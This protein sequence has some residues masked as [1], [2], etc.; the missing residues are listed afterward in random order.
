[1]QL[2]TSFIDQELTY[3]KG[4]GPSRSEL[5]KNELSIVSIRDILVDYPTRYEDRTQFQLIKDIRTGNDVVQIRGVITSL[6]TVGTGRK[7]RLVGHFKDKSGSVEL[8]W[9]RSIRWLQ[10]NL[11]THKPYIVFGRV[12]KF[13]RR[14]SIAHPELELVTQQKL[15]STATFVP[16]Y[17]STE[18]L[19][20]SG[21]DSKGRRKI[22]RTILAQLKDEDLPEHM[23]EYLVKKLHFPSYKDALHY[24][25]FPPDNEA[26]RKAEQRLK[27]EE[28]FLI[29][30]TIVKQY[31]TRRKLLK[32]HLFPEIGDYFNDFY[33]NHLPFS[34]TG[35]QKRVLKEIRRDFKSGQQMN[36]LL[37]GDVGSGKTIVALMS[38][39]MA[40]DNG[41]QACLMAPTEILAQQ[42][43]AGICELLA[44]TKIR[45][46]ILTG[47]IKGKTRQE[48]LKLLRLGEIHFLVG[49]HALIEE[50]VQFKHLG[51][52]IID[53]QHRFGVAQRA[54]LW[55]KG[56]SK[57]P[58][59]LVMTA[60]PIPRTL[61]MTLYGDLDV[62]A[63]DELP[64]GRK[65][66]KTQHKTEYHR[67]AVYKFV[68]E[69]I[70]A[71]RQ[72]YIV[73][74]LIEESE[75]LDLENLD[76]G[77]ERLLADFPPPSYQISVVHGR[78]KQEQKDFE[79]QRFVSG[80]THLMVATTVIEVGVNV[81]N[82][83]VMIIE[84]SERFGL[85]QL[86]QLRGRV[87]RGADQSYCILMTSFK[88]TH[89]AKERINTMVSTNDGFE[90]A[91]VDLRLRGPGSMAGTQQ[92]GLP[93][94]KLA[95]LVRD[96]VLLKTAREIAMRIL[97]KDPDLRSVHHLPLR[98]YLEK[99]VE[100]AKDWSKIS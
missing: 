99:Y 41:F 98:A 61:H 46:A 54:K 39:L 62:S 48:V 69:Q 29:Q 12:S 4:V 89:E 97:D 45:V 37:Q 80:K 17:R 59:I 19:G 73:Y 10:E 36:R 30:L 88:L 11:E 57:P 67:P 53:E 100:D 92:S 60:T 93:T 24:I 91:E 21:L 71:G 74:P 5:L 55:E 63:L 7:K 78:M 70:A 82:A 95:N 20:A 47:S 84:N 34:L 66:V 75:H 23:P 56:K 58:H 28:L 51:L 6:A 76:S 64:P 18:R 2:A 8:V 94:L 85:S 68:K 87:G 49:T 72:I 35:A 25:H 3:I 44:K 9:F 14:L 15:K 52:A 33:A 86:H 22:V 38:M 26:L 65:P 27:F 81:P 79:M 96:N 13:G 42:H 43:M 77:Y 31:V 32:G 16:I 40:L 50:H 1:M 90:I 83:S